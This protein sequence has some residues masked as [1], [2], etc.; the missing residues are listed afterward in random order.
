MTT[1]SECYQSAIILLESYIQEEPDEGKHDCATQLIGD[2]ILLLQ[3]AGFDEASEGRSRLAVLEA[4]I[5]EVTDSASLCAAS[6]TTIADMERLVT[7]IT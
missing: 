7:H 6:S 4:H 2:C 5:Q 3:V 1:V